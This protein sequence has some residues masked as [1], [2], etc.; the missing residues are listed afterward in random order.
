MAKIKFINEKKTIDVPNGANLREEA[1]KAEIPLY[2]NRHVLLNCR[3]KG[4]C[5]TCRVLI[6]KGQE[7]VSA[8]GKWEK[9]RMMF[10]P[11]LVDIGYEDEM[12]LACQTTVNGDI[13]VETQPALLITGEKFWE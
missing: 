5:G 13:E 1:M 4:T 7:S 12:R 2:R 6:K 3:G 11:T 8:K 9:F 10:D